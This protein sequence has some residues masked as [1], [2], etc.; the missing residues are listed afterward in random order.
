VAERI[1]SQVNREPE[2]A[3]MNKNALVEKL[4]AENGFT[5]NK[6]GYALLMSNLDSSMMKGTFQASRVKS[7]ETELFVTGNKKVTIH[8]FALY[9][10]A[11]QT[12]QNGSLQQIVQ[13]MYEEF[14]RRQVMAY[15]EEHLEE[16]YPAFRYL[17][18][19][20]HDGILLFNLTEQKVWNKAIEDSTGLNAY[21]EEIKNNYTWPD[22][23][24]AT[25]YEASNKEAYAM[26]RK[27][28]KKGLSD[29]EISLAVNEKNP[30]SLVIKRSKFEKGD[31]PEIDAVKWKEG[32]YYPKG[33]PV[34]VKVTE[35]LPAGPKKL[36][37][38][39]GI[40]T[41]EYQNHL[42]SQWLKEL[43][44]AYPVTVNQE[45]LKSLLQ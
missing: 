34:I 20:Y 32:I 25:L 5:L 27:L 36:S 30:L 44:S 37:E 15:E 18:E 28:I 45:T 14:E 19:E 39:K 9:I 1:R 38:V 26:T 33:K 4:K 35:F 10:Q 23:L 8:D 11:Y 40:V 42:E 21:Y 41:G 2:R 6:K 43:R 12:E 24:S 7:P 3:K 16:K 31:H 13:E 29:V 22:R 17:M